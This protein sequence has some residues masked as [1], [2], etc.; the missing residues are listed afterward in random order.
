MRHP[1][2][3][4]LCVLTACTS[5]PQHELKP[6]D[7][8]PL[9]YPAGDYGQLPRHIQGI[10][11]RM[12]QAQRSSQPLR[13]LA[14]H[15]MLT[16]APGYSGAWQQQIAMQLGLLARADT[17]VE[18]VRGYTVIPFSGP[19]PFE[20]VKS[21]QSTLRKTRWFDP[22]DSTRDAIVF[23]ELFWAP[24]RDVIKKQF[25]ACF[26]SRSIDTSDCIPFTNAAKNVDKRVAVNRTIKD[27]IMIRGL[28]DAA[29]V[30]GPLGDIFRDDVDLAMCA[31]AADALAAHKLAVAPSPTERCDLTRARQRVS[32]P[33]EIAD[34][35]IAQTLVATPFVVITHSLG[36]FLIMDGQTRAESLARSGSD[37]RRE[38]LAFDLMDQA[39]VFMYANQ[40]PLLQLG[41]LTAMC[42]PSDGGSICPNRRLSTKVPAEP[43]FTKLTT[44]VGFNDTNDLLDF[45]IPPYFTAVGLFGR[46]VNVSVSNP[47]LRV[48][49]FHEPDKS[50]VSYGI[51][52][53]IVKGVVF[54]FDLP[55]PEPPR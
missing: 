52:P 14:V 36:G 43:T 28:S 41:R 1:T 33:A 4:A 24:Y 32:A 40:I 15:G 45:E 35:T 22:A 38:A 11:D 49:G 3:I 31:I 6:H 48:P 10:Q 55:I 42:V 19:Q 37:R 21:K 2:T 27:N 50:H 39:T 54:G 13:I 30:L 26:D 5:A 25:F 16:D 7:I 12:K 23:Y 8:R 17:L 18:I 20:Q 44:Y 47:V 46:L 34:A 9:P 51:N 53:A 29:L